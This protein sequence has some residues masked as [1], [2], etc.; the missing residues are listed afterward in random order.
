MNKNK[1]GQSEII[2][3]VLIILLVL[4]AIVIVWQVVKSTVAG[5][6][7]QIGSQTDCMTISLEII[8]ATNQSTGNLVLKRNTGAGSLI[9]VRV[10]LDDVFVENVAVDMAELDTKTYA[11]VS[12]QIAGNA[13]AV[14]K[15]LKVAKLTGTTGTALTD[16]KLCEFSDDG[17]TITGS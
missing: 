11:I 12:T 14:G 16:A 1:R 15:N 8:R 5:G 2:T 4:A 7:G 3:T 10:Y 13:T 6:A 17:I 9:G